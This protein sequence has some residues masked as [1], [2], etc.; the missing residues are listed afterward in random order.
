LKAAGFISGKAQ[1]EHSVRTPGEPYGIDLEFGTD[2]CGFQAGKGDMI[3]VY[4]KVIDKNGNLVPEYD[5]EV[6]F[7]IKGTCSIIGPTSIKAEAGIAAILIKA[8]DCK[9]DNKVI[10]SA[11]TACEG[12]VMERT[13]CLLVTGQVLPKS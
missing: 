2:G 4:A 1:A 3:F 7:E 8:G 5:K 10:V 11:K 13:A 9:D 6:A 12:M